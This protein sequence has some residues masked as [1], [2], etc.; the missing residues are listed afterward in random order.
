MWIQMI[1]IY[2]QISKKHKHSKT[3]SLHWMWLRVNCLQSF[4][5][6]SRPPNIS[7][8]IGRH[9]LILPLVPKVPVLP[10]VPELLLLPLQSEEI[11]DGSKWCMDREFSILPMG[12]IWSPEL[13]VPRKDLEV[14]RVSFNYCLLPRNLLTL[15]HSK[16]YEFTSWLYFVEVLK[17]KLICPILSETYR[18]E[19]GV[20]NHTTS[21]S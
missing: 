21:P 11:S 3:Q 18:S 2:L 15:N 10:V 19:Q 1:H 4:L 16:I 14:F 17:P 7:P 9:L 8:N 6:P 20:H 12:E 13:S 5:P